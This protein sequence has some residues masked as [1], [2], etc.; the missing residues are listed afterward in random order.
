MKSPNFKFMWSP[1]LLISFPCGFQ[2]LTNQ[3]RLVATPQQ[4]PA[5]TLGAVPAV[6]LVPS[7]PPSTSAPHG[8]WPFK[9]GGV[10]SWRG[11]TFWLI[12]QPLNRDKY[13]SG[14]QYVFVLSRWVTKSINKTP[15]S[16]WDWESGAHRCTKFPTQSKFLVVQLWSTPL[17]LGTQRQLPKV[18]WTCQHH[19]KALIHHAGWLSM[20]PPFC[21]TSHKLWFRRGHD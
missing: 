14:D 2:F 9:S 8:S 12:F 21:F 5:V 13:P 17:S 15:A 4:A 20:K 18:L 10:R 16:T 19:C 1:S 6:P 11:Q 3:A 7:V